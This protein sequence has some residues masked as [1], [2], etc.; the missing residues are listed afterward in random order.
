MNSL[1][2]KIGITVR[3]TDNI[4]NELTLVASLL[5]LDTMQVHKY[6]DKELSAEEQRILMSR[7]KNRVI[8]SIL[9]YDE[10]KQIQ[11][12]A[13]SAGY[14]AG[15]HDATAELDPNAKPFNVKGYMA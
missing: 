12:K 1:K 15:F 5:V 4:D 8:E 9:N 2:N 6:P 7:V 11:E 14:D 10:I 13:Y 3:K